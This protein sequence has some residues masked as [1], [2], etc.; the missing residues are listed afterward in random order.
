MP[1]IPENEPELI[2]RISRKAAF[3][4]YQWTVL[5]L[6]LIL[7]FLVLIAAIIVVLIIT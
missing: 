5:A 6:L 2:S 1:N 7:N 3:S 4:R